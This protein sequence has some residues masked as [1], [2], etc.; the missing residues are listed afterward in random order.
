VEAEPLARECLEIREKTLEPESP[1]YWLLASTRSML[2]G[3]L[4]GQGAA[5]I[6]S[7]APAAIAKFTEAEPLLVEAGGWLT[8]NPDRV[9]QQVRAERL[10]Q[11]LEQIVSLYES[12]DTAAPDSGKAD[13]AGQWRTELQNLP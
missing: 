6:A 3:A 5:L 8:Q 2:G 13:Q 4:A 7:N 1:D 10:R 12:W 11:A 9:P